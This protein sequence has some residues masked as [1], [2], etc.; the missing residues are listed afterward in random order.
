MLGL[1]KTLEQF[2]MA[3]LALSLTVTVAAAPSRNAKSGR[4]TLPPTPA[5]VTAVKLTLPGG[6]LSVNLGTS[7]CPMGAYVTGVI[8]TDGPATVKYTWIDSQ[9]IK[10]PQKTVTF[11]RAGS[12]DVSLKWVLAGWGNLYPHGWV[13]TERLQLKILS[14]N[15]VFSNKVTMTGTCS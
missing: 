14:P 12:H 8:T 7:P 10:R 11:E 9:G 13:M 2:A 3:S 4:S 1:L 15:V 5:K 6:A